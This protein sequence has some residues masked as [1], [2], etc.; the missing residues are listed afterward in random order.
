MTRLPRP[1][2]GAWNPVTHSKEPCGV[3]V[4]ARP[5]EKV[6]RCDKHRAMHEADRG[7]P[8]QRGFD[9]RYRR[10]RAKLGLETGRVRCELRLAGC[11]FWADTADHVTPR[12]RGGL[13]SPLRP[14]CRHCNSARGNR[15]VDAPAADADDGWFPPP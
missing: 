13:R 5:G 11:T 2:L 10:D 3:A 9:S 7:S 6:A 1:C 12:S 14:A 8:A 15:D 4:E